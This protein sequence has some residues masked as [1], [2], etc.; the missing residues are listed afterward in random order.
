M[1]LINL[2]DG[3]KVFQSLGR[4]VAEEEEEVAMPVGIKEL[5]LQ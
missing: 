1:L 2:E 3:V 4:F 5:R